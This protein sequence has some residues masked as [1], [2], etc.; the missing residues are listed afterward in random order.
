MSASNPCAAGIASL[1]FEFAYAA[2][3]CPPDYQNSDSN[4]NIIGSDIYRVSP[5]MLVDLAGELG[6]VVRKHGR[7]LERRQHRAVHRLLVDELAQHLALLVRRVRV[8]VPRRRIT[9]KPDM[10][11]RGMTPPA[12]LTYS[13]PSL[14]LFITTTS[15]DASSPTYVLQ[16]EKASESKGVLVFAA[17][18]CP[19]LNDFIDAFAAQRLALRVLVALTTRRATG[20]SRP[21][22]TSSTTRSRPSWTRLPTVCCTSA[23]LRACASSTSGA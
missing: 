17:E 14:A 3:A 1:A 7:V 11:G 23:L 12:S 9:I 21:T 22:A 13:E 10:Q 2:R 6:E 16:V 5:R 19:Y 8:Q 4:R 15:M 18:S 20:C